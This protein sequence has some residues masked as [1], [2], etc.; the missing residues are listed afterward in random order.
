MR[1]AIECSAD[2]LVVIALLLEDIPQ[3]D[4]LDLQAVF[5]TENA[6]HIPR[7]REYRMFIGR[8][9]MGLG[10]EVEIDVWAC[11]TL[12]V[13]ESNQVSCNY[14]SPGRGGGLH[15]RFPW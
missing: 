3:E 15:F 2:L 1:T 8:A 10:I 5:I 13:P 11:G 9:I 6:S 14:L 7:S 12:R 4:Q